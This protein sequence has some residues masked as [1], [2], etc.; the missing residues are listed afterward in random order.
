MF[1]VV[2]LRIPIGGVDDHDVRNVLKRAALVPCCPVSGS[3]A[4]SFCLVLLLPAHSS[5]QSTAALVYNSLLLTTGTPLM[6]SLKWRE[7]CRCLRSF[8]LW[9]AVPW[10]LSHSQSL[11]QPPPPHCPY[12]FDVRRL[13]T[14]RHVQSRSTPQMRP[15]G[16]GCGRHEGA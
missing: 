16:Q 7:F 5:P 1:R 3:P 11:P 2:I 9:A 10:D 4:L 12:D 8:G 15:R 13:H 6:R 14:I